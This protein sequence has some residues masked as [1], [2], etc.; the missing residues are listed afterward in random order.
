MPSL[1]LLTSLS[2]QQ[3]VLPPLGKCPLHF[4]HQLLGGQVK[5]AIRSTQLNLVRVPKIPKFSVA[6]MWSLANRH[7]LFKRYLPDDWNGDHKTDR[8]FF[9]QVWTFLESELVES[10]ILDVRKQRFGLLRVHEPRPV[11][12]IAP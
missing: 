7:S 5:D 12:H 10:V 9:F 11:I 3:V 4:L 6:R 8:T 1:S 2:V